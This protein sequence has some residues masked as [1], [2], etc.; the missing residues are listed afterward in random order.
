MAKSENI[1]LIGLMGA[2]KTTIGRLLA[3]SLKMPFYDFSL[4]S[5]S[6][7]VTTCKLRLPGDVKQSLM[8]MRSQARAWERGKKS[9]G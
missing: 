1:Y 7:G 5:S 9:H 8:G 6:L 2:G 4:P 3:K